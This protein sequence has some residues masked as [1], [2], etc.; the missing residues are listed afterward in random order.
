[1]GITNEHLLDNSRQITIEASLQGKTGTKTFSASQ[2]KG[3]QYVYL[4]L[5]DTPNKIENGVSLSVI[6]DST[7]S[8]WEKNESNNQHDDTHVDV[9]QAYGMNNAIVR[10][11][12]ITSTLTIPAPSFASVEAKMVGEWNP[13][14]EAIYPVSPDN[15]DYDIV[16]N[17]LM[18]NYPGITNQQ[19][20]CP[21]I[22]TSS[23]VDQCKVFA[24]IY[25]EGQKF[26]LVTAG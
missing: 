1:M 7:N 20:V 9:V 13:Y 14:L 11:G 18:I 17:A 21:A 22:S 25:F 15:I 3:G 24:T 19:N 6:V 12:V 26:L 16:P 8:V 23:T 4:V 2:L 5:N 10:V